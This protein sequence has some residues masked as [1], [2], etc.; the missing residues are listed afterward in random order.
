MMLIRAAHSCIFCYSVLMP[1]D[2]KREQKNLYVPGKTPAIVEVPAMQFVAVRGAGD[3]NDPHGEYQSALQL[4]YGISFTI[5]M[6]EKSKDSRDHIA[7]Y[8]PY[9][10]PPLEG[11][12]WMGRNA[13]APVDYARKQDFQW[14]SM[15][16]L[17]EFV[18]AD[19]FEHARGLFANKHPE[20]DVS[21]ARLF[22]YDE[23]L[24]AQVMHV[25]PYDTEPATIAALDKFVGE[26]G[27]ALDFSDARHHHEIYLSNPQRCAPD[28]LRTVIRHP[29][30]MA[31]E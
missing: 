12:W 6:S 31:S 15:I 13:S 18:T 30:R 7:G 28:R 23:G 22:E 29:V 9:V 4:L 11:L 21:R 19:A 5:K 14:I 25:G 16:R 24:C 3:P 17:P 2:V 27:Y 1:Y 8:M 20:A 10:V 26:H